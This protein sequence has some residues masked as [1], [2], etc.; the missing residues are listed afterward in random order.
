MATQKPCRPNRNVH[1]E[2]VEFTKLG[3]INGNAGQESSR[4][5]GTV[6][7]TAASQR[8]GPGFKSGLG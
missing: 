1:W 6:V 5:D 8:Q 7:S 2:P 4:Y 3:V